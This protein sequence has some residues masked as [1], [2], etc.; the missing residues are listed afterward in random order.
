[1][2]LI[3]WASESSDLIMFV[4]SSLI[5]FELLVYVGALYFVYA[6]ISGSY[7][8]IQYEL[9]IYFLFIPLFLFGHTNLNLTGFDFTNCWREALEGP[10]WQYYI[11]NIELF[12][13]IWIFGYGFRKFIQTDDKKVKQE[14]FLVTSG[15]LLFLLSFSIGNILGSIETDWEIGQLGLFGMPVFVAFLTLLIVRYEVFRAK[16][17]ATEA[18]ISLLG[19]LVA[20]LLFVQKIENVQIIASMT[21]IMTTVLGVLLIRSVRKEVRQ[22]ERIEQLAKNLDKANNRLKVL[23][24]MKSEFVSIASHQLRSPLTSIRGY[25]S[26]LLEGSYGAVPPK[27]KEALQRISDSSK[28][29]IDSVEDYLN[30]SRIESGNMKYEMSDFNLKDITSN[31]VD[32]L[33]QVAMQKGLLL[34]FTSDISSKG[35]VNADIGKT[36]QALHNLINN[37]IKYTERGSIV[38]S[39][40]ESKAPKKILVTISDTGI[41]MSEDTQDSLFAKFSRAKD[42]N[43]TNASGT[44]LGLFVAKQMIEHMKGTITAKSD[45]PGKGSSFT[46]ELPL[47]Q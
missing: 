41:G 42:A 8:K 33:R 20:S 16:I 44:G 2:D 1:M 17:L 13:A 12:F 45:G 3:L 9:F 21:L 38:V 4:W 11:Y 36:R 7:P 22:R 27:A 46:L 43:K 35:I 30:V 19:I 34:T 26:M 31:V 15:I 18:L 24:K 14:I 23:D 32:E 10:L 5:Y 25:A 6:F 37:S 29:M 28:Y 47:Q 39:V 40:R